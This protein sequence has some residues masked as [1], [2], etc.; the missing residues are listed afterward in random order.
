MCLAVPSESANICVPRAD[1]GQAAGWMQSLRRLGLILHDRASSLGLLR[2]SAK[3]GRG[4][5]Q[6][7]TD[8][9]YYVHMCF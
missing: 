1:R 4:L 9:Y 3:G 6:S 2:S 8:Y 5:N 7:K